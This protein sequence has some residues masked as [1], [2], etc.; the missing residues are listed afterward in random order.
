MIGCLAINCFSFQVAHIRVRCCRAAHRWLGKWLQR[1]CTSRCTTTQSTRPTRETRRHL[2]AIAGH[3]VRWP[4]ARRCSTLQKNC[5]SGTGWWSLT[6]QRGSSD[7]YPNLSSH[8]LART[9]A[10]GLLSQVAA[11][12]RPVTLHRCLCRDALHPFEST[13]IFGSFCLLEG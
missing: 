13:A 1:D 9:I 7:Q 4:P 12:Q 3:W 11:T 2:E 6:V 5:W 8:A 10:S